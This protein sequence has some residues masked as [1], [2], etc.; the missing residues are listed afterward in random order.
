[1]EIPQEYKRNVFGVLIALLAV[2]TLYFAMKFVTEVKSYNLMGS[3][4]VNTIT[5]SG[6]GEVQAVPDIANVYFSIH[7]DG[8]TVKEAQD[9]VARI[10]AEALEVLRDNGVED[11]DIQTAN[12]SFNPKYEYRYGVRASIPCTPFSCPPNP[13][14]SVIVGYEAHESINVKVRNADSVGAIMQELGNTGVTDL[15]GPNFTV[16]NEDELKAEARKKAIQDAREK[17]KVLADDLGVRLGRVVTFSES[18]SYP[19][20]VFNKALMESADGA[21]RAVPPPELPKGENTI[22]SEV[23]VTYE[24]R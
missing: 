21:G 8:K 13:S 7:Q 16:E 12:A 5:L 4:E 19:F 23:T 11:K 22:T 14:S 3:G 10:E 9:K 15:S 2:L 20:A 6:S 18:G 17:A 24:I 1:M